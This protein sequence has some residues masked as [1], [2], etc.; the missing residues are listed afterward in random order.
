VN[1]LAAVF[2]DQD[3]SD[4]MDYVNTEIAHYKREVLGQK[5]ATPSTDEE[6]A[7]NISI[8]TNIV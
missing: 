4:F 8:M 6:V 5:S 3:Y 2:G 7:D 1:S